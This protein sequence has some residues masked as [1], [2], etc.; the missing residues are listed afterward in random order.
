MESEIDLLKKELS[1]IKEELK[2]KSHQ[3]EF[4]FDNSKRE[5]NNTQYYQG[6]LDECA[7]YIGLEAF[8]SDDGVVHEIP[9]RAKIPL[10]VKELVELL[11]D[12]KSEPPRE[13]NE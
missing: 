3:C 12:F 10:C 7:K 4:W 8:V 9:L 6:L 11:E 2:N 1:Q 5:L 13:P